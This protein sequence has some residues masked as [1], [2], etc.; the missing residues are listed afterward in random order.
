MWPTGTNLCFRQAPPE[1]IQNGLCS[2]HVQASYWQRLPHRPQQG[3]LLRC[4]FDQPRCN[5][6]SLMCSCLAVLNKVH[7]DLKP[8]SAVKSALTPAS[9]QYAEA[10]CRPVS[11]HQR[12]RL[13][14]EHAEV[15]KRR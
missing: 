10:D 2:W 3:L 8:V 12:R 6:T 14:K 15:S 7:D 1:C 11:V 5:G 13:D 4:C 9:S